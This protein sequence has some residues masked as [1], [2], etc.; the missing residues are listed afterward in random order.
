MANK[1]KTEDPLKG[2]FYAVMGIGIFI[3]LIWVYCFNLFTD[4][5]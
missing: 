4:R 2:S 5:F 1:K 3:I